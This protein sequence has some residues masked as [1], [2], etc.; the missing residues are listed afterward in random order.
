MIRGY[1][2]GTPAAG[3]RVRAIR[4]GRE[5]AQGG[6]F[7]IEVLVALV[8]VL[9]GLL[10][11]AGVQAR[12]QVAETESYQRAQAIVLVQDMASRMNANRID[13][14]SLSYVTASPL[15]GGGALGDCTGKTGYDLDHCEWGNLLRG[16][17]ET[18]G[19][20]A[21]STGSG[22]GCVGVMIGARG[23]V[24]YDAASAFKDS[25]G[26]T[27]AG[28]GIYTISV[29]WQGLTQTVAPP[30]SIT[31]GANSYGNEA[32]RRAVTLTLRIGSLVAL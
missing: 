10:G 19:G 20:A 2:T 32:L 11:L 17:A 3:S 14:Q 29:V 26:A 25:T 13:A 8:I 16:A 31:C 12:A 22:A 7:M 18:A 4:A 30:A 15:G 27:L 1:L 6:Y 23:C 21:C 5:P 24:G 28:T 9:V